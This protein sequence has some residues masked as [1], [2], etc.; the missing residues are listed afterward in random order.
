MDRA[1]LAAQ[2]SLSIPAL[3]HPYTVALLHEAEEFHRYGFERLTSAF[4]I[5][6]P[7]LQ[8]LA[9]LSL[10][11]RA[12]TSATQV[13]FLTW[14]N[15]I[16]MSLTLAPILLR[17]IR[18]KIPYG[19]ARM[20]PRWDQW[21]TEASLM[22]GIG[23]GG[24]HKE[25]VLLFQLKDWVMKRWE[26][27]SLNILFDYQ[28]LGGQ[29]DL[30]SMVLDV[31]ERSL[32]TIF[33]VL[34][35]SRALP[36]S[37]TLGSLRLYQGTADSL[38][39]SAQQ[40]TTSLYSAYQYIF[41]FAAF[42]E[43]TTDPQ[44]LEIT[45]RSRRRLQPD[46][47]LIHYENIRTSGG[48]KIEA[49][50]LRYTYPGAST[51]TLKN[52]NLLV[53][54]G[55]TLAIV[56]F[57][58][59]GKTTLIKALLRL[60]DHAGELYI[61]DRPIE[62][63]DPRSLHDRMSCLFQDFCKYSL[64]LHENVGVGDI[65]EINEREHIMQ[66]VRKGGADQMAYKL[67][68]ERNLISYGVLTRDQERL[69]D[70]STVSTSISVPKL[71]NKCGHTEGKVPQIHNLTLSGDLKS[72]VKSDLPQAMSTTISDE[73]TRNVH[74]QHETHKSVK[75]KSEVKAGPNLAEIQDCPDPTPRTSEVQEEGRNLPATAL[76]G[77]QWQRIA[78]SRAF[79][80]ADRADLIVFDEPSSAL[81]PKAESDLFQ[82]IHNLSHPGSAGRPTTIYISHR[83][84]TVKKADKIAV[85]ENGTIIELGSHDE[86]IVRRGRYEELFRLQ[87]EGFD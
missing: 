82:R 74:G 52:I 22:K 53:L 51:P 72:S 48:M 40:L 33:Y 83:F 75:P 60:Y 20:N 34:L 50:N 65:N 81:D 41:L 79:L 28:G 29:I 85:V 62:E 26:S 64:T 39:Y 19:S 43:A 13:P 68:L 14:S 27:A 36:T 31:G 63:F 25:E 59:G 23:T 54:P 1:Y 71:E 17:Y 32:N 84:S 37:L 24:Y 8:F 4:R 69:L 61:N 15:V 30:T 67:G 3:S 5:L 80:R 45:H 57:N 73:K 70:S 6:T 44:S 9:R 46:V 58:G 38:Y 49:R 76:S 42:V 16:L 35:A 21:K 86:L 47:P 10:V 87:K 11:I 78:L 56:G 55:E 77:G 18:Q 2:I 66:A 12:L 7:I